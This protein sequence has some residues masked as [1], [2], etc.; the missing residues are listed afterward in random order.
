MS[1][2]IKIILIVFVSFIFV[3]HIYI[4]SRQSAQI[5]ALTEEIQKT[6]LYIGKLLPKDVKTTNAKNLNQDNNNNII[7][8]KLEKI[9]WAIKNILSNNLQSLHTKKHSNNTLPQE[10]TQFDSYLP[11]NADIEQQRGAYEDAANYIDEVTENYSAWTTE[12]AMVLNEIVKNI[13]D[14]DYK[15][16]QRKIALAVTRDGLF[17][18]DPHLLFP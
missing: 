2:A 9:E 14:E 3:S 1:N 15:R 8:T 6:N 10:T 11:T 5:N 16:I 17:L 18:E 12:N 7:I 4:T 13:S